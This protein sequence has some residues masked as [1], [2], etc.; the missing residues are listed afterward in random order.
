[1]TSFA[2][3]SLGC[4]PEYFLR[5]GDTIVPAYGTIPGTKDKPHETD[6]GAIQVDGLAL[7]MNTKPVPLS[8]NSSTAF[9]QAVANSMADLTRAAKKAIGR[10]ANLF[11]GSSASFTNEQMDALPEDAK[12][13][14]CDP[15]WNAYTLQINPSPDASLDFRA[16]GGHIHLG[17]ASDQPVEDPEYI[18]MCAEIVKVM[19]L[20]IGLPLAAADP[21]TR[22]RQMYGKAGAFRPKPYGVEYRTPSNI[23][24]FSSSGRTAVYKAVQMSIDQLQ[25]YGTAD[26][27]VAAWLGNRGTK[28]QLVKTIN[29]GS[30]EE[31]CEFFSRRSFVPEMENFVRYQ[32]RINARNAAKMAA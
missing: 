11:K 32:R 8:S 27:V 24:T 2:S 30:Y 23:W 22:R 29:E 18:E 12:K 7:E 21:D 13:L 20:F 1:M 28:E 19:D 25:Y 15:D 10:S 5:N 14:G 31:A 4:D 26:K 17:W 16:A 6:N 9:D 3:F